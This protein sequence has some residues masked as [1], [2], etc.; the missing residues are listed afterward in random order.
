MGQKQ[1]ELDRLQ[2]Q[3]SVLKEQ[4]EN[5]LGREQSAREGY[6]LQVLIKDLSWRICV[7][8]LTEKSASKCSK[9]YQ[10]LQDYKQGLN[11]LTVQSTK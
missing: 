10:G 9:K 2:K 7:N 11:K 4:L 3:N 6:V 8:V 5:A 1:K